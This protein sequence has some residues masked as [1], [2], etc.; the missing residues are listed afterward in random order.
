MKKNIG[1]DGGEVTDR[2]AEIEARILAK[3]RERQ[4]EGWRIARRITRMECGVC[5][6]L[7]CFGDSQTERGVR[8]LGAMA[9]MTSGESD[10]FVWGFDF[11]KPDDEPDDH[12]CAMGHRLAS[13]LVDGVQP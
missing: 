2:I 5:C 8:D 10:E 1:R 13:I 6:A 7:G 12:F 9:G 4:A 11:G 3:A